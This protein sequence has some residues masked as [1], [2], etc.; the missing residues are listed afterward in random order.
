MSS[1]LLLEMAA[2]NEKDVFSMNPVASI[3]TENVLNLEGKGFKKYVLDAAQEIETP[4]LINMQSVGE[5]YSHHCV[6]R[7]KRKA[8]M[9]VLPV[10]LNKALVV[11]PW[12][13]GHDK[14]LKTGMVA[15][16]ILID[17]EKYLCGVTLKKNL[18]NKITPMAITLKDKDLK[19]VDEEKVIGNICVHDNSNG[20]SA[21]GNDHYG[22]AVTSQD[23]KIP[24]PNAKLINNSLLT[25]QNERNNAEDTEN[26]IKTENIRYNM[27]QRI[28][29]TEGDLHRII[30]RCVNEAT[31]K[32][33]M[34]QWFKDME[35]ASE[36]RER[37]D[38]ITKGGR[39]PNS[40]KS[41]E[42]IEEKTNISIEQKKKLC[43]LVKQ[44]A[45][46]IQRIINDMTASGPNGRNYLE[47]LIADE[48][49]FKQLQDAVFDMELYGKQYDVD[50]GPYE[51]DPIYC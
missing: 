44:R 37:M 30:R 6:G 16:P 31:K 46:E 13:N 19:V 33:P 51:D 38:Y 43:Q 47:D 45:Y 1:T 14:H 11:K 27:K 20:N 24:F 3:S 25:K 12:R 28:R 22:D 36:Y 48:P 9:T 18:K 50:Y 42:K 21:F 4:Y 15:A 34:K 29:L 7:N 41:K 23:A 39:K 10:I 35:N 49:W 32:D 8:A 5:I 17:G 2:Y 26:N 40:R